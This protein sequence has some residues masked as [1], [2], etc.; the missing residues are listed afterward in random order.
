[1]VV[2]TSSGFAARLCTKGILPLRIMWMTKTWD[3][4]PNTNHPHWKRGACC[5][6]SA[7]MIFHITAKHRISNTEL[8][9]PMN[10]IK[11]L[12]DRVS[13]FLGFNR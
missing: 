10:A 1:M 5:I 6:V 12:M 9:G 13:H 8:K 2:D 7:P 11:D 4:V 3:T